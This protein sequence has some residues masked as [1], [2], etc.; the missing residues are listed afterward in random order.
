MKQNNNKKE[1]AFRKW[2][3][4]MV[5]DNMAMEDEA[6][7]SKSEM[8]KRYRIQMNNLIQEGIY[9]KIVLPKKYY[10]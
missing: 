8:M 9:K 4:D 6:V 5:Y 7:F 1:Q 2:F 3:I 10:A